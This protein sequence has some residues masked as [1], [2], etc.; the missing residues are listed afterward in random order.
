MDHGPIDVILLAGRLTLLDRSAEKELVP[1]CLEAGT[2]LVVGGIFNSGILARR[3][4]PRKQGK[5]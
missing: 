5:C 1:R 3:T 2:S 4:S